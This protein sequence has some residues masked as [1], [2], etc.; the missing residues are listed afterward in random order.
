MG[1]KFSY[2]KNKNKYLSSLIIIILILVVLFLFAKV[3]FFI[4][5]LVIAIIGGIW[6]YN[7][8]KESKIVTSE[9]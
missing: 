1:R 7:K 8:I 6:L 9:S 4:A 2:Q 5:L 3:A